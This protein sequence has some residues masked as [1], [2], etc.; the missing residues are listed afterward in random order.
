[1]VGG[2]ICIVCVELQ[3]TQVEL[4]PPLLT[5]AM[6]IKSAQLEKVLQ[7]R[8]VQIIERFCELMPGTQWTTQLVD[9][10][11]EELQTDDLLIIPVFIPVVNVAPDNIGRITAYMSKA[12]NTARGRGSRTV[13]TIHTWLQCYSSKNA[14]QLHEN[15]L[16]V[17][18]KEFP[19]TPQGF[20]EAVR[21]LQEAQ[22]W[23]FRRG[24]CRSCITNEPPRKRIRLSTS[25]YCTV[26][27]LE[28]ALFSDFD[29]SE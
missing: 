16:C 17:K 7:D 25:P 13:V 21:H 22:Q 23:L 24:F 8:P 1:M 2:H 26:C 6:A 3:S 27:L 9:D 19:H 10:M 20:K 5:S 14:R 15:P 4:A 11:F 18:K 28:A 12:Y 29:A